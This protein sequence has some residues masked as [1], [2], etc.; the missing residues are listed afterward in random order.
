M[1][2]IIVEPYI[3]VQIIYTGHRKSGIDPPFKFSEEEI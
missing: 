3:A 1:A 2:V